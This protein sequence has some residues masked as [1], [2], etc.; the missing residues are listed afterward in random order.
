[1]WS[2]Q[3]VMIRG[4]PLTLSLDYMQA[5]YFITKAG[6]VLYTPRPPVE[7]QHFDKEELGR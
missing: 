4:A 5:V 7:S 6:Q 2:F 1:M 3:G